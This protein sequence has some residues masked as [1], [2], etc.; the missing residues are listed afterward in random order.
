MNSFKLKLNFNSDIKYY[1]DNSEISQNL[2]KANVTIYWATWII[3]NKIVPFDINISD[4]YNLYQLL[5]SNN[6]K[7]LCKTKFDFVTCD[8]GIKEDAGIYYDFFVKQ[9]DNNIIFYVKNQLNSFQDKT[10]LSIEL[11]GEQDKVITELVFDKQK[12]LNELTKFFNELDKINHSTFNKDNHSC[13]YIHKFD[14]HN[15]FDLEQIDNKFIETFN[16]DEFIKLYNDGYY[17]Y[18][19]KK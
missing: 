11:F 9:N 14:F 7:I 5:K 16:L 17:S 8:C 4:F 18:N 1:N 15:I 3:D 12:L 2:K 19:Y 6:N 10:N 13:C